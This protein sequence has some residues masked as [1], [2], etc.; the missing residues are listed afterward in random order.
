MKFIMSQREELLE[1]ARNGHLERVQE[2]LESGIPVD[3]Y[4]SYRQTP[5]SL[6]S[7]NGHIEVVKY[8]FAARAAID[9]LN[10]Y[11][12]TPLF[13]AAERGHLEIVHF[14][15]SAKA[16][17]F[18]IDENGMT[19]LCAAARAGHF[20]I[21]QFLIEAENSDDNPM[22]PYFNKIRCANLKHLPCSV[23]ISIGI[24]DYNGRTPLSHAS[25]R[26]HFEIVQLLIEKKA[27]QD[28]INTCSYFSPLSY[29]AEEG[30]L[31]TVQLL[32]ES[33]VS[34]EAKYQTASHISFAAKKGHPAIVKYLIDAKAPFDTPD[35]YGQTALFEAVIAKQ[36]PVVQLLIEEKA[37]I[38]N[39]SEFG[40][41]VLSCAI[42]K[43][44]IDIVQILIQAGAWVYSR[45]SNNQ[46]PLDLALSLC[47]QRHPHPRKMQSKII[48]ILQN[49]PARNQLW[50]PEVHH[51]TSRQ[52]R[53][54]I[55]TTM[56]IWSLQLN[57][58][59]NN[60]PIEVL[61]L[62]FNLLI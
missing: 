25:Q 41:T 39:V 5:F 9:S 42:T 58:S 13:K 6:A 35:S 14:L 46:T 28:E 1:T 37:S 30:H 50:S 52:T 8:L 12:K 26:G 16:S 54:T 22:I 48:E 31:N 10:Q 29:A 18:R 56:K 36:T 24:P 3:C 11:Q 38:H 20:E 51:L 33:K 55:T 53:Q 47:H 40:E 21:V 27:L 61:F 59:L 19:I 57:S 23:P 43:C 34:L 44:Q 60:L 32:V 17:V 49:S 15:I 62:I 7:S 4:D 2:L 45:D